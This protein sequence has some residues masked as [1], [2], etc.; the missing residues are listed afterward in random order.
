VPD[1]TYFVD[2]VKGL[3]ELYIIDGQ[4]LLASREIGTSSISANMLS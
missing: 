3:H 2:S 4:P 1:G